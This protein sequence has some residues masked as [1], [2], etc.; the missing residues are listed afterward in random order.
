MKSIYIGEFVPSHMNVQKEQV[1]AAN[2]FLFKAKMCKYLCRSNLLNLINIYLFYKKLRKTQFFCVYLFI[3][4][5][6]SDDFISFF[7]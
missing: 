6:Y 3:I 5:Q 2:L 1:P 4:I 7:K